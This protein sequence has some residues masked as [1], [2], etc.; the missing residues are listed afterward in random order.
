MPF[1][2]PILAVLA[3][4]AFVATASAQMPP[5]PG[6]G[7][8]TGAGGPGGRSIADLEGCPDIG[9]THLTEAIG[10]RQLDRGQGIGA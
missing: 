10:Y 4:C 7:R 6:G 9:T 1:L 5:S 8:P 3:A 2:R